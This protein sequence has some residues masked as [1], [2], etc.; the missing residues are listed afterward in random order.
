MAGLILTEGDLPADSGS[1]CEPWG[2]G[3]NSRGLLVEI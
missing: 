1:R 3:A 2:W